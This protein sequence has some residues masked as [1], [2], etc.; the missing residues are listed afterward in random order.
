[1]AVAGEGVPS[2]HHLL[3]GQV[4]ARRVNAHYLNA[5]IDEPLG[6]LAGHPGKVRQVA[7][8]IAIV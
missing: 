5:S 2:L 7:R 8:L 6:T 4:E 1:M 3:G